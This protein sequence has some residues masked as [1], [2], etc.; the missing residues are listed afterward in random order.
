M[1][2]TR[3]GH[4]SGSRTWLAKLFL[5]GVQEDLAAAEVAFLE[6]FGDTELGELRHTIRGTSTAIIQHALELDEEPPRIL[7]AVE[8]IAP[9]G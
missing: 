3:P 2:A 7:S 8:R 1:N 9:C 6:G 4:A 5:G